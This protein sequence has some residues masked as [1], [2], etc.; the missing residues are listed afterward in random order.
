MLRGVERSHRRGL[1]AG[2]CPGLH[3]IFFSS[4]WLG[5][6][7]LFSSWKQ[8]G[9]YL[10]FRSGKVGQSILGCPVYVASV[11]TTELNWELGF[12]LLH[13][14]LDTPSSFLTPSLGVC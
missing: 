13:L 2:S 4:F 8:D 14:P 10:G 3:S 6:A 5:W 1:T 11:V 9:S 7:L 12:H